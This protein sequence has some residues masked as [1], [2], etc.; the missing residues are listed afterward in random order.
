VTNTVINVQEDLAP[1]IDQE[2]VPATTRSE[3]TN[4]STDLGDA[5][6]R[7]DGRGSLPPEPDASQPSM[8]PQAQ[9][10]RPSRRGPG[11]RTGSQRLSTCQMVELELGEIYDE[12]ALVREIREESGVALRELPVRTVTKPGLMSLAEH[13]PL[14]VI[15]RDNKYYCIG[16]L[17]FFRLFRYDLPASTP[18]HIILQEGLSDRKLRSQIYFDLF[19]MPIISGLNMKDRRDLGALWRSP[20]G[21]ELFNQAFG[22]SDS[23]GLAK[24]LGCDSRTLK[25]GERETHSS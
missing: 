24:I 10:A 17:R 12:H 4:D 25:K 13:F 20:R 8:E 22:C 18:L 11:S 16:G 19:A 21:M 7:P 5:T 2:S 1:T 9:E 23:K 6:G 3:T 15:K 14:H